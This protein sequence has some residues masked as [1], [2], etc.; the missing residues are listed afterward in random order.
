[1]SSSDRSPAS[2]QRQGFD[3]AA[4][5]DADTRIRVSVLTGFLGSGKTTILNHLVRSPEMARALVVINEFGAIGLDH[6]LVSH[7]NEDLVVEMIGGCLCC[8]IR[9]DLSRTLCEAPWRFA[10]DGKCWFDRVVIETTGLADPAPILHTLMTDPQL[11]RLYRLDAVLTTVDAVAGMVT[12]DRQREAVKQV[13]VADRLLL[14]KTDLVGAD[15]AAPLRNRL[16]SINPAAPVIV[17]TNGL[18]DPALLFDVGLWDPASKSDDVR[19][20]LSDEAYHAGHHH[21]VN[22]HGDGIHA[23]CLTFDTPL[24]PQAFERWLGLLTM[25][26]CEDL[27]RVKG[28]VHLAG[29]PAPVVVHGVQHVFH[30]PIELT[31]WPSEDRRTRMVFITRGIAVEELRGTLTL[32]TLGLNDAQL[33]GLVESVAAG[34]PMSPPAHRS[35]HHG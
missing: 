20:W 13:A 26:R 28:I 1:M 35:P 9:G 11:E 34:G 16:A 27:L 5:S 25:F 4:L 29:H 17:A 24:P 22:R 7:A 32:M 6:D 18:I 12:L 21:D 14:T 19:R 15:D 31:R 3:G 8:T 30:P 33:C 23:T 10:R 2:S